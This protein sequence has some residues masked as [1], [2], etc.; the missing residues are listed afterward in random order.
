MYIH[1]VCTY[2]PILGSHFSEEGVWI[3]VAS[4]AHVTRHMA[5]MQKRVR[6]E[7]MWR[8]TNAHIN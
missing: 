7:H 5:Q 8:D 6:N 4:Q 3:C 1:T 2:V